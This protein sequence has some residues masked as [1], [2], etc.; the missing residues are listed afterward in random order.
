MQRRR[1]LGATAVAAL[2]LLA[3]ACGAAVSPDQLSGGAGPGAGAGDG[4]TPGDQPGTGE[5]GGAPGTGDPGG[6][7]GSGG[8]IG[9]PLGW[10]DAPLGDRAVSRTLGDAND[11]GSGPIQIVSGD[12]DGAYAWNGPAGY[13]RPGDPE[14]FWPYASAD[15]L[16][17]GGS[18]FV[19]WRA[20]VPTYPADIYVPG[21]STHV[22]FEYKDNLFSPKLDP[23]RPKG[24]GPSVKI[25]SVLLGE[26]EAK[27]D[28]RWKRVVLAIPANAP[29]EADGRYRIRIG[30]G[31]YGWNE[32][33]GSMLVHRIIAAEGPIPS[34]APV[35][36]FWPATTPIMADGKLYDR[37]GRPYVPI[38]VNMPSAVNDANQYK[39][40]NMMGANTNIAVG[41]AEGN[42][43]RWWAEGHWTWIDGAGRPQEQMGIATLMETSVR[44]GLFTS[45][46]AFQD[47]WQAYIKMMGKTMT[48]GGPGYQELYDGTWRGVTK[49][50][51]RA[52]TNLVKSNPHVPFIYLKDEWDHEDQYWG[53]LEEQVLEL[54]AI[55]NR[56]APGV[57]T[58][59]AT[60]GWKPLMHRAGF[61]LADFQMS[62]TYPTYDKLQT[63]ALFAESMRRQAGS[64][65]FFNIVALSR[66]YEGRTTPDKWLG[67]NYHRPA[68]Y[69]NLV[70]GGRGIWFWGSP[71]GMNDPQAADYYRSF[72]PLTDEIRALA[73]VI[74]GSAKELGRT[75][76]TAKVGDTMY[77]E[78]YR[79]EGDGT[80]DTDGV[81]TAYRQSAS[82]KVLLTVNEWNQPLTARLRVSSIRAGDRIRVLFEDRVVIADQDGSFTDSYAPYERH[83]YEIPR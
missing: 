13:E 34:R 66:A 40:A 58:T 71:A 31:T 61:E 63:I 32:F 16:P 64:R 69:M 30:G 82:R 19:R 6:E 37:Q 3:T 62:D 38:I 47:T 36:G 1:R 49:V 81:A 59:V 25:G 68:L 46:I 23:Y 27:R 29:R 65:A 48:Y 55:A 10:P 20:I 52:M 22:A 24:N 50:F 9:G 60:M 8:P 57:P 51:E 78:K 45:P 67:V 18:G 4:T 28:H 14:G 12:Q 72:K 42:G 43:R 75:V 79:K 26:L 56:V 35:A 17:D 41:Y 44:E 54:R 39:A 77:P 33:Y 2:W 53:S 7:P 21:T 11:K 80:S 73:D 15:E 76:A 70:H 83:V 74:H 5:P